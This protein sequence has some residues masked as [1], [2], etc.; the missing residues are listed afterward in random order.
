MTSPNPPK[1]G[2]PFKRDHSPPAAKGNEGVGRP[3]QLKQSVALRTRRESIWELANPQLREL[4]VYEPGKPIEETARELGVEPGAIVKLA[5]NENPLG[6]SPKAIQAMHDALENAHLYPDGSGLY[7]RKSIATKLGVAPDNI[8]LGNGSNEVIEFL[9]HAFLNPGDDVIT[10]QHAFIVYKL[11][12]TSFGARAIEVPAPD[13]QQDLDR[14]L[15]AITPK[16]RLIFVPNPNNP[17]GTLISQR[18][19]DS[20]MSRVPGNIIVVFDE[21]YFEFLNDPPDT[22]RYVRAGQNVAVLRTFSKIHGLAGLRIGYGVAP[23]DLIEVLHKTRQPF[24]VNSIAHAGALAALNDAAH[25]HETKRVVDEGR[26][27]LQDKLTEMKIQFVPGVANFVMV[28]VGDGLAIF[29]QLLRRN[30]I[31]RPLKGYGLPEWVRISVGTIEENE[32]C[33]S[34]LRDVIRTQ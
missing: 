31:V 33:V 34:A 30:I 15:D 5:S 7:L 9:G 18:K 24:N 10:S 4:T 19:I 17:T 6:P 1:V 26:A 28:N 16:T 32:K 13:F 8:I 25:Q 14:M 22:R 29:D 20:F 2:S 21:A 3:S 23:V 12:A 27:Y 11:L